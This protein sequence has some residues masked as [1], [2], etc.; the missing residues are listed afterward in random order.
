MKK[1]F[2][3]IFILLS[4]SFAAAATINSISYDETKIP[5]SIKDQ[6]Y[7]IQPIGGECRVG[8]TADKNTYFTFSE[9]RISDTEKMGVCIAPKTDKSGLINLLNPQQ[10]VTN[11]PITPYQ[12]TTPI[13]CQPIA[14]GTCPSQSSLAGYIARF[15]QFALM[16]AGLLAFG[17]IVYAGIKYILSAGNFADQKDA[18]DQI[19]QAIIG[20]V[21]LFGAYGALYIVNP[22]LVKINEP[23]LEPISLPVIGDQNG[24]GT[25]NTDNI[26]VTQ[27]AVE[28]CK[29]TLNPGIHVDISSN[30]GSNSYTLPICLQCIDAYE[31]QNGACVESC[32]QGY[33]PKDGKCEPV[34][35]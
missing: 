11:P 15:Y 13:P 20:L 7:Y 2:I 16:I 28:H 6:Y 35:Y 30:Q 33:I 1:L 32:A 25:T 21:L 9:I 8:N 4:F 3:I 24:N 18:K 14:G 29:L 17:S 12:V 31:L 22:A 10:K 19:T 34:T 27:T 5:Q 23:T 26:D